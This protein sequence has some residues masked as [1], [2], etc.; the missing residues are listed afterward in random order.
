MGSPETDVNFFTWLQRPA[1]WKILLFILREKEWMRFLGA[2]FS[3]YRSFF[4]TSY[5]SS[6]SAWRKACCQGSRGWTLGTAYS[7]VILPGSCW[8]YTDL[9]LEKLLLYPCSQA[10]FFGGVRLLPCKTLYHFSSLRS[11]RK[12]LKSDDKM[13]NPSELGFFPPFLIHSLHQALARR[14]LKTAA[15]LQRLK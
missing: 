1:V 3:Q 11:V 4:A 6:C 9:E 2:A 8:D 15:Y 13:S 14:L 5:P 12:R 7:T 10:S